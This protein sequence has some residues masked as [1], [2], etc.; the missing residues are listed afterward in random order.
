MRFV[1]TIGGPTEDYIEWGNP[2]PEKQK[3]HVLSHLQFLAPDSPMW[4]YR[5]E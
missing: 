2:D 4:V 3:S 1:K 5:M